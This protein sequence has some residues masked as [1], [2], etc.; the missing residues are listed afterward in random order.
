MFT[1]FQNLWSLV[2][3]KLIKYLS[4]KISKAME[5]Y[6]YFENGLVEVIQ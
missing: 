4:Y 3:F 1:K 6:C 2:F 5:F